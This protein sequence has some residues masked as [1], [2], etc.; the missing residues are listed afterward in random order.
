MGVKARWQMTAMCAMVYPGLS[1]SWSLS[2][3][4][5]GLQAPVPGLTRSLL[6]TLTDFG[7]RLCGHAPP[8]LDACP[9]PKGGGAN[10]LHQFL[11]TAMLYRH[12][13]LIGILLTLSSSDF[14]L[15]YYY[16]ILRIFL[17]F[18]WTIKR[19]KV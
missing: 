17:D 12:F 6:E 2:I 7:A 3:T 8:H 19:K 15:S 4:P 13:S 10:I 1:S 18:S 5:V 9:E 11:Q 14:G 16:F